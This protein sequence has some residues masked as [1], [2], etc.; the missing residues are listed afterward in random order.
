MQMWCLM[1]ISLCRWCLQRALLCGDSENKVGCN[2]RKNMQLTETQENWKS[3]YE[4]NKLQ[5]CTTL[6]VAQKT[7]EIFPNKWWSQW[8]THGVQC[9]VP[10]SCESWL[11][12]VWCKHCGCTNL[13][14]FT[15][16]VSNWSLP[17]LLLLGKWE[18]YNPEEDVCQHKRTDKIQAL[19]WDTA[20]IIC[21]K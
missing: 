2:L 21:N 19:L 6:S 14:L 4:K 8:D 10:R 11:I 15:D 17:Y 1:S 12:L 13:T 3:K 18:K 20:L 5:I 7:M 16:T 9:C